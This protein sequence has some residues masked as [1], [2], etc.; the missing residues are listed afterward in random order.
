MKKPPPKLVLRGTAKPSKRKASGHVRFSPK[1]ADEICE[2]LAN[3][4]SLMQMCKQPGLPH[5]GSIMR[6]L[7][8]DDPQYDA[9]RANYARAREMQAEVLADETIDIADATKRVR[10]SH[11]AIESARLRIDARKWLAAKMRP[12][13]YGEKITHDGSL[14]IRREAKELTDDE[15]AALASAGSGRAP[16]PAKGED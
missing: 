9:F 5:R 15:L 13:K 2:R 12:K 1:I 16:D 10:K 4:E 8:S 6:W 7:L 11:V 3:G 14:E